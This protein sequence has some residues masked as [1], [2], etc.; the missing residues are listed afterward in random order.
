[1]QQKSNFVKES[2][3]KDL[4]RLIHFIKNNTH[5]KII[6]RKHPNDLSNTYNEKNIGLQNLSIHDPKSYSLNESL[7]NCDIAI[8]IRSSAII[9]AGRMGVIPLMLNNF[10]FRYEKNLEKLRY[11]NNLILIGNYGQIK[12]SLKKILKSKNQTNLKYKIK[13][14]FKENIYLTDILANKKISNFIKKYKI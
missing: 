11:F 1:M 3:I 8:T 4:K 9:E 14:N 7:K 2:E 5:K 6:I 12:N 13:K 10:K